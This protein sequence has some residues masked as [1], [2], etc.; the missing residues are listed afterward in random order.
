M[1]KSGDSV[2]D[3]AEVRKLIEGMN[4]LVNSHQQLQQQKG[5]DSGI[6]KSTFN[7]GKNLS[8]ENPDSSIQT[9]SNANRSGLQTDNANGAKNV[10]PD[11]TVTMAP[12]N[13]VVIEVE[14]TI[15][16]RT[17]YFSLM[18]KYQH[19]EATIEPMINWLRLSFGDASI[20]GMVLQYKGLD[21]L[22]KCLLNRD[23]SLKRIL[24]QTLKGGVILKMR[25]P[26][27]QDLQSVSILVLIWLLG[28]TIA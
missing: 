2:R 11:N 28:Q 3:L 12:A 18:R 27:A 7:Q 1:E 15:L 26:R 14:H 4:A 25:V 24:L 8:Y 17:L 6:P 10:A 21:G 5:S 13:A 16:N 9:D 23:D 20:S 22:W 19:S